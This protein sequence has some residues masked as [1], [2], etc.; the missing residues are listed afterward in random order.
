MKF[1]FI[2]QNFP[3]QFKFLAPALVKAGH[4]VTAL[5]PSNS[6]SSTED[7]S[8]IEVLVYPLKRGNT[9]GI[10]DWVIDLESK[11]IRGQSCAQYALNMKSEGFEPDIIIAHPGWG[12]SLFLKNVWPDALLKIYCEYY[13]L[14]DG[15]DVGFDPEYDDSNP[16]KA[17][18]L[19][20]KNLN[21]LSHCEVA[22]QM[23]APTRWQ[24]STFPDRIANRIT[25]IHDG[26]DTEEVSPQEDASL[27]LPSG[28]R[29]G[30]GDRVVTYVARN[31]EPHRGFHTFMRALPELLAGDAQLQ[32]LIVGS[33]DKGYGLTPASG[34][35]WKQT[36]EAETLAG[37]PEQLR[38]RVHFLGRLSYQDYLQVLSVSS[39][40]V[41]LTYPFVLS[42]SLMEAMSMGCAIVAS[43]TTPVSEVINHD[44]EGLLVDFFSPSE[45]V[46][47]VTGLL[48]DESKRK[49]LGSG[50]RKKIVEQ[51]DLRSQCLPR[52]MEWACSTQ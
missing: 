9:P 41:Y 35:S 3:G 11:V 19:Q 26:V 24:A 28:S 40:H 2:H 14:F 21:I 8:G 47:A 29:V 4:S 46:T 5:V 44:Q 49:R 25:V 6:G 27:I 7:H 10:H 18:R 22:D 16:L 50:A 37:V 39:V 31:L 20:M 43:D 42:W 51:Y 13:Y 52:L 36:L 48:A 15:G 17:S 38:A 34:L 30:R 1:L 12:E 45:I 32:V 33:E 23:L